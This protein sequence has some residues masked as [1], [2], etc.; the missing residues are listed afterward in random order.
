M[1]G[2]IPRSTRAPAEARARVAALVPGGLYAKRLA[3][4]NAIAIVGD[5]VFSHAGVLGDWVTQVDAVNRSS[6]CWLDGQAGGVA[7][8]RR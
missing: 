5:T 7:G 1:P 6:R 3:E 4:H 2:S 8:R